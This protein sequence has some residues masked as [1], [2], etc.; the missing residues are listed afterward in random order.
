VAVGAAAIAVRMCVGV[1]AAVMAHHNLLTLTLFVAMAVRLAGEARAD[2]QA[3]HAQDKREADHRMPPQG[4][5]PRVARHA[6]KPPLVELVD[7]NHE[8]LS[9]LQVEHTAGEGSERGRQAEGAGQPPAALV[10][11]G[12][13]GQHQRGGS[14]DQGGG[15]QAAEQ[16]VGGAEELGGM[17]A[18][19]DV[20]ELTPYVAITDRLLE[21]VDAVAISKPEYG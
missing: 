20:V 7:V 17:T 8:A 21:S 3:D 6:R 13:S 15:A 16:I 5:R 19:R 1:E 10:P 14:D 18:A 4:Q 12:L 11:L 2:D 9:P